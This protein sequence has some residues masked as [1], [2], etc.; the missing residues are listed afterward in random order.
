MAAHSLTPACGC[1]SPSECVTV[2][3]ERIRNNCRCLPSSLI[4]NIQLSFSTISSRL[5]ASS[6]LR[7]SLSSLLIPSANHPPCRSFSFGSSSYSLVC[8]HLED[9]V[10]CISHVFAQSSVA[11]SEIRRVEEGRERSR[12]DAGDCRVSSACRSD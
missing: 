3:S 6:S 8:A 10:R 1:V 9:R 4:M 12:G 7:L 5:A 11:Y 2:S